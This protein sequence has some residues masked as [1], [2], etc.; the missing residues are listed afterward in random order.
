LWSEPGL[1]I[2]VSINCFYVLDFSGGI[3][4]FYKGSFYENEISF[5]PR[6]S[7]FAVVGGKTITILELVNENIRLVT[8]FE[9]QAEI[10]AHCVISPNDVVIAYDYNKT[11]NTILDVYHVSEKIVKSY[12]IQV[13]YPACHLFYHNNKLLSA[14]DNGF[15]IFDLRNI[16]S[17]LDDDVNYVDVNG[18]PISQIFMN[19]NLVI[20]GDRSAITKVWSTSGELLHTIIPSSTYNRWVKLLKVYNDSEYLLVGYSEHF[21]IYNLAQGRICQEVACA[22]ITNDIV[23]LVKTLYIIGRSRILEYVEED[24]SMGLC[25]HCNQNFL[26]GVSLGGCFYHPGSTYED[27]F[28]DDYGSLYSCCGE[29]QGFSSSGCRERNHEKTS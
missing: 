27:A 23:V 4:Y 18:D 19:D 2:G 22:E 7:R 10:V 25:K 21:L 8:S 6:S 24:N 15:Q 11:G 20:T 16:T 12:D 13:V 9:C 28:S 26:P 14:S 29:R 1:I 17:T 5:F 3:Y